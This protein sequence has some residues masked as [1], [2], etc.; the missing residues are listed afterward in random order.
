MDDPNQ[1]EVPTSFLALYSNAAGTR[2]L[3]P[4]RFVRERYE[5]CEDLAQSLVD[6]AAM[7]LHKTGAGER[8]VL[9]A[10]RTGLSSGESVVT[11]TEAVWTVRRIAELAG[12][13]DPGAP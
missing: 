10:V 1:I 8:D 3:E 4:M 5:L 11:A 2:L 9:E 12:W 6:Q 13:E 7:T